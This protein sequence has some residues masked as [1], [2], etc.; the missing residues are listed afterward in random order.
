MVAFFFD[1]NV[2]RKI[3]EK[4]KN[5]QT[6]RNNI[7]A[8]IQSKSPGGLRLVRTPSSLLEMV[9]LKP[10]SNF[11]QPPPINWVAKVGSSNAV[12][13]KIQSE[14]AN[15]RQYYAGSFQKVKAQYST[16]SSN[17]D[18]Q[19]SFVQ[20]FVNAYFDKFLNISAAYQIDQDVEDSFAVAALQIS[21]RPTTHTDFTL[22]LYQCCLNDNYGVFAYPIIVSPYRAVFSYALQI[23]SGPSRNQIQNNSL[24]ANGDLVDAEGISVARLGFPTL[25]PSTGKIQIEPIT[26]V[27]EDP[28][29][30]LLARAKLF[31]EFHNQMFAICSQISSLN[32]NE[33]SIIQ[34]DP[35][36]GIS[37]REITA[38]DWGTYP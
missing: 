22:S 34:L 28:I 24:K 26:F 33:G 17:W 18:L 13:S 29:A 27:T 20:S 9:G 30:T 8:L 11:L 25:G 21:L 36:T 3:V 12:V 37:N 15:A 16:I 23:S 14:L 32:F 7:A 4:S 5:S 19:D 10:G 6:Y 1:N 38:Q 31:N 35:S 2:A